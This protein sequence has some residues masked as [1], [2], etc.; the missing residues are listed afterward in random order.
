MARAVAGCLATLCHA[1]ALPEKAIP[2]WRDWLLRCL[3][4]Q[5]EADSTGS[6]EGAAFARGRVPVALH[7]WKEDLQRGSV[8]NATHETLLSAAPVEWEGMRASVVDA[9]TG[10]AVY[11]QHTCVYYVIVFPPAHACACT[12]MH[13]A[14]EQ[15][16]DN[17]QASSLAWKQI[18]AIGWPAAVLTAHLVNMHQI[19]FA[20]ISAISTY[21]CLSPLVPFALQPSP[22][23]VVLTASVLHTIGSAGCCAHWLHAPCLTPASCMWR[24]GSHRPRPAW[25]M[26]CPSCHRMSR[27]AP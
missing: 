24:D 21:L 12:H 19:L 5:E 8:R 6:L 3:L 7:V 18:L 22:M 23:L 1:N 16:A 27:Y 13:T 11:M 9:L 14:S 17:L 10:R 25:P 4:S 2:R 20:S 26:W 15:E